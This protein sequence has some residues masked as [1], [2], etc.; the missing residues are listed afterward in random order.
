[1]DPRIVS[2]LAY[3]Q[4]LLHLEGC[5]ELL[6]SVNNDQVR[7]VKDSAFEQVEVYSNF[8]VNP[9]E[10]VLN[11]VNTEMCVECLS[12]AYN[13][14][15]PF[16]VSLAEAYID[17][18]V[19]EHGY[20]VPVSYDLAQALHRF[21]LTDHSLVWEKE[22]REGTGFNETHDKSGN[23]FLKVRTFKQRGYVPE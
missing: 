6:I 7:V 16:F 8:G 13:Y 5:N 4:S 17:S 15:D 12:Q 1:M 11:H 9:I 21:D 3:L 19:H 20:R 22:G 14:K 2:T 23:C 10:D 18:L